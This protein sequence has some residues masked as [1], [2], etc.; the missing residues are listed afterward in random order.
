MTVKELPS[1]LFLLR[2]NPPKNPDGMSPVSTKLSLVFGETTHGELVLFLWS[3]LPS[4]LS[5]R[6][7]M[8]MDAQ[9]VETNRDS[10]IPMIQEKIPGCFLFYNAKPG[11]TTFNIASD[12]MIQLPI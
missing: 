10:L 11:E 9:I 4:A 5:W 12:R 6:L 3:T 2:R 7:E 8:G 1:V